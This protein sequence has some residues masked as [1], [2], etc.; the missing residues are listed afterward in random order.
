MANFEYVFLFQT[1]LF[2][3]EGKSIEEPES[4][5]TSSFQENGKGTFPF[6]G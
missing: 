3:E 1:K 2:T 4:L 5:G 6:F